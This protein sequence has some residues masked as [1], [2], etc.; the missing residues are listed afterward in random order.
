MPDSDVP[1]LFI[2]QSHQRIANFPYKRAFAEMVSLI[3]KRTRKWNRIIVCFLNPGG[4]GEV[5]LQTPFYEALKE[6]YP[7]CHLTV[8]LH[9]NTR[10]ALENNPRIDDLVHYSSPKELTSK[11]FSLRRTLFDQCLIFDK[12]WKSIYPVRL[13]IRAR[14]YRGF[15]RRNMEALP[16]TQSIEYDG[17]RHETSFYMQLLDTD[18]MPAW[19]EPKLYP[20]KR[21]RDAIAKLFPN[22]NSRDWICLAA[23]GAANQSIGDDWF[24]RWPAQ[25]Y[26]TLASELIDQGFNILLVGGPTDRYINNIIL[27]KIYKQKNRVC[28]LTAKCSII[29]SG[30]AMAKTRLIITNDS[31]IMHLAACFNANLLCLFGPTSPYTVLPQ[32]DNARYLWDDSEYY[33]HKVRVFGTRV[34]DDCLKSKF[35]RRLTVERVHKSIDEMLS[36]RS[37]GN[38]LPTISSPA[39]DSAT[40][41]RPPARAP[42]KRIKRKK[43]LLVSPF[44]SVSGSAVRFWNIAQNLQSLGC[45][46]VYVERRPKD[47][48]A[49]PLENIRHLS[50]PKLR[51]L[52]LDIILS[53]IFNLAVYI[54]HCTCSVF[55]ALKPAPN[56]CIPALI[57]KFMGKKVILDI[58]DLDFGYI[59][60]GFK[61]EVSRF[62]FNYFPRHF[63]LITCHT[64]ALKEYITKHSHV[65]ERNIYFLTQGL[66]D[67][68][69]PYRLDKRDTTIRKSIVYLATLGITSDFGDL[70]P[71][72]VNLC[73]AHSDLEIKIIGDGV[74]KS[75]FAARV[76]ELGL[77]GNVRFLGWIEHQSIPQVMAANWIGLAYMR[78]TVTN[79]CRAIL[80]IREY[81]GVGLQ[82]VCNDTGDAYLFKDYIHIEKNIDMMESRILSLLGKGFVVNEEGRKYLERHFKWEHIVEKLLERMQQA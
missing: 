64:T 68:F 6:L 13:G 78:P 20:T 81:L 26:A 57:A 38:A 2:Q 63:K 58:D 41:K 79:N 30:L 61:H 50:S 73:R 4:I 42:K 5:I 66:S 37:G 17:S 52:F 28:D 76:E 80:K 55:Y 51:N 12:T 45:D 49:P 32:V 7:S 75:Y 69:L 36:G 40:K 24:R 25:H 34:I 18:D 19:G 53:T 1:P 70:L 56:N 11:F 33:N 44:T 15:K 46:V 21:D 23:G 10:E 8:L 59:D 48:P 16:L 14:E 3:S 9:K 62:F 77:K 27:K 54:R 47:A 71:M 31:G 74:R 60:P 72:F 82:V 29:Q 67:V 22:E 65:P 35:F 43:F 39:P